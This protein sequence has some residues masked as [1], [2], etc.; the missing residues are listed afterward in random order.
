MRKVKLKEL[1][2][3]YNKVLNYCK[4]C[5]EWLNTHQDHPKSLDTLAEFSKKMER[6]YEIQE[7]IEKLVGKS[8]PGK[9]LYNGFPV[10]KEV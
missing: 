2:L 1:K 5:E 3:K 8:I 10:K 6:L 7:E 9:Y 4:K